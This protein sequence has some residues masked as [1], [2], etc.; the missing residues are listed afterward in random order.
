MFSE[1]SEESWRIFTIELKEVSVEVKL[2][3]WAALDTVKWIFWGSVHPLQ[4]H[5]H[6][7]TDKSEQHGTRFG[8]WTKKKSGDIVCICS[9]CI[10]L[11]FWFQFAW[12]RPR[13][14]RGL[15]SCDWHTS[16]S[17]WLDVLY[18]FAKTRQLAKVYFLYF[19]PVQRMDVLKITN[20][21]CHLGILVRQ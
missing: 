21:L 14:R 15:F 1:K 7:F 10:H 8:V 19:L 4:N 13:E 5:R 9:S 16:L 17:V 11:T 3:L 2:S 6:L 18:V 12:R 20:T